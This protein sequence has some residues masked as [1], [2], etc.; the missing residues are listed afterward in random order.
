MSNKK[1]GELTLIINGRRRYLKLNLHALACLESAYN[2]TDI[3]QLVKNFAETGMG[4]GDVE[5]II[6]AGLIG[7]DDPLC[8]TEQ[9]LDVEG[10]FL[11]AQETAMEL[12]QL[13]L[14]YDDDI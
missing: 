14:G 10:G 11:A 2:D 1:R 12:L 6:R 9:S 3:L 8:E 13:A 5:K 7:M 4:A